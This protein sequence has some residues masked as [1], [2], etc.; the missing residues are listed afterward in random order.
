MA[1]PRRADEHTSPRAPSRYHP[2]THIERGSLRTI[3]ESRPLSSYPMS[4][5]KELVHLDA[6]CFSVFAHVDPRRRQRLVQPR[7]S[8]RWSIRRTE[9]I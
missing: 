3:S 7:L 6:L 5:G 1:N 2:A 8:P 9:S 4:D